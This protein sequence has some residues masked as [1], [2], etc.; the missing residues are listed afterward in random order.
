MTDFMIGIVAMAG[1]LYLVWF[2]AKKK[3]SGGNAEIHYHE[4][5]QTYH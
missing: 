2:I 5:E 4:D 3:L 1:L